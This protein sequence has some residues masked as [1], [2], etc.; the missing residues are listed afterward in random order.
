M[1]HQSDEYLKKRLILK[2]HS[3][4][5]TLITTNEIFKAD[6]PIHREEASET[7]TIFSRHILD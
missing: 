4:H 6:Y 2:V 1:N 3:S 7:L 5:S